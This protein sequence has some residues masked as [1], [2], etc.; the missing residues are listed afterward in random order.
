MQTDPS[1]APP[2]TSLPLLSAARRHWLLLCLPIV[3]FTAAAIAV[4]VVRDPVYTAEARLTAGQINVTAPGAVAGFATASQSLASTY[5]R[6]I[7]APEI[8]EPIA[9]RLGISSE[10]VRQRLTA[11]PFPESPVVRVQATGPTSRGAISLANAGARGLV[12]YVSSLSTETGGDAAYKAMVAAAKRVALGRQTVAD[13]TRIY[14]NNRTKANRRRL[15]D[16]RASA[17]R[18]EVV[19]ETRRARYQ[20]AVAQS[21]NRPVP[22]LLQL[23]PSATSDKRSKLQLLGFAGF[24]AGLAVG[25]VLAMWRASRMLRRSYM[26]A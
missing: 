4:G 24:V 15:V 6:A 2:A 10:R 14:A 1:P 22:Q 25:L 18:G 17:A 12:D 16:A 9:R 19:F 21:S 26:A 20:D 23:A 7:D 8:T 3:A 5:S 13:R 11:S